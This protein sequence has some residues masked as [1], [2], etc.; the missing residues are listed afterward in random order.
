MNVGK[1]RQYT[2]GLYDLAEIRH[3]LQ[4]RA[5]ELQ[6]DP[7]TTYDLLLAITELVTNTMIYG[8]Q[9]EP[10]FIEAEMYLEKDS[11]IIHLRDHA[12]PFNPTQFPPPDLSIPLEKRAIGGMGI[13]LAK[14]LVDQMIYRE[15]PQGGNEV[16]LVIHQISTRQK[17][18][19]NDEDRN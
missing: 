13:F 7:S 15:L 14:Q 4:K 12:A 1:S 3:F 9:N 18:E 6:V 2:A 11:L 16:T 10:G 8:Y 17:E 19:G 5:A